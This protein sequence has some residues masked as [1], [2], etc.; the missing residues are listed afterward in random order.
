MKKSLIKVFTS[1]L[2]IFIVL[3]VSSCATI[4]GGSRYYAHVT[5]EDHPNATITYNG[6]LRGKG[7][8]T[9][10]LKRQDANNLSFV[11]KDEGC[12]PQ[13]VD[14]V[15]RNFRT[16]AFIGSILG[17][18]G[19]VGGIPIP[20]GAAVDLATGA[21]WKPNLKEKGITKQDNKNYNYL[22]KYSGCPVK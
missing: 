4:F 11:I 10:K 7:F 3:G 21:V 9:L 18:T 17:W 13:T 5:V 12:E 6:S 15:G 19:L 2:L 16:G 8:A 14:Y 1:T 20:W 22:I